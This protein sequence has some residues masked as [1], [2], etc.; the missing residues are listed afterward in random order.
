MNNP[1]CKEQQLLNEIIKKAFEK[2]QNENVVDEGAL[3][4]TLESICEVT[5]MSREEAE[6]IA[7]EVI[8]EYKN[9]PKP[10]KHHK[11]ESVKTA[12]VIEGITF[13]VIGISLLTFGFYLASV[14]SLW[15]ILV[16]IFSAIFLT[17]VVSKYFIKHLDSKTNFVKVRLPVKYTESGLEKTYTKVK[18]QWELQGWREIEYVNGGT[19][20]LSFIIFER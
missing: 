9:K 4:S 19:T 3:N 10:L 17:L 1:D 2:K 15:C 14:K 11:K 18:R 13:E 8:E 12:T 20:A 6:E 16:L 7:S 5:G